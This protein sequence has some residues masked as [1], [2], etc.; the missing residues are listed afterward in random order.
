MRRAFA[1]FILLAV[2][3]HLWS[4]KPWTFWYWMY[5]AV[6]KE[7]IK[8]DLE[9][10]KAAGL[11]GCYLMPIRGVEDKP[12]FNG[13]AQQLSNTFW[14]MI[15]Y[16]FVTA[17]QLDLEM[18]IHVSDGFALAGG[19]WFTP[20][21]SMQKIVFSDT[22]VDGGKSD[23]MLSRPLTSS[24]YY[25]DIACY[26]IPVANDAKI[27]Y[28]EP[29]VS[30]SSN[31]RRDEKGVFR[32]DEDA[33][34]TYD[35]GVSTMV[36]A[37]EITPS[38]NNIQSQRLKV[39]VSDDGNSFRSIYQMEPPRQG[40]QHDG[41][42]FT[43]AIPPT[44]ARYFRLEW[45]PVGTQPGSE[46]LD[47]AKWRPNL[48]IS[49]IR[50]SNL[51]RVH[52][53]EGKAGYVWRV[54][55]ESTTEQLPESDCHRLKDIHRLLL[56]D[57]RVTNKLPKGKWLLLRIGHTTTGH[58]NATAGGGKGLEC[59]KFSSMAVTKQI[60]HWFNEFKKRKHSGVVKYLHVDSWECGSQ[61][62]NDCFSG[63]FKH[64]RQYNI[65]PYLPLLCGY[66]I[67]SA[68]ESE[69]VLRD[70]RKTI[71]ELIDESFFATV[72]QYAH[73][74]DC[75]LSTESVAPT[76]ISDGLTHYK[77]ADY[78]MGEFWLNSPTHD[79]PNDILDAIS[80]AHIYGK[81][82]VQAEGFTEVRGVWNESPATIKP[83][84]DRE[85]AL[86]MNKLF[87]HVFTH[88]PWT[89][90]QPGMTLDGIGL[91]FQRD[92]TWFPESKGLT[93]YITR[94]QQILQ[95]RMPVVDVAVFTG[96]EIPSRSLRPDQLVDILPG[97]IGKERVEKVIKRRASNDLT[98]EES[99]VGVRHTAGIIDL[100]DWCNA[101]RG[102]H[103]DCVN[104]EALLQLS[105]V[106]D[107]RLCLP[108]G[109][110]YRVLVIPGKTAMN[111]SLTKLS[112]EIR[113]RV[114]YLKQEGV[115][116]IE[117]PYLEDDFSQYGLPRD[118]ELPE[119]VDFIHIPDEL[120]GAR[121]FI[122]NQQ[123]CTRTI[124]ASFRMADP[125]TVV[126]YDPLA[127]KY[128]NPISVDKSDGRTIVEMKLAA[129]G[130]VFVI[131]ANK[132]SYSNL[133]AV[134]Y[135]D[136]ISITGPWEVKFERNGQKINAEA[137][138]DWS[139][140]TN[141]LIKYY[142]GYAAYTTKFSLRNFDGQTAVLRLD[143]LHDVAHVYV[144]GHDCGVV[145][146]APYE[147]DITNGL[148]PGKNSLMVKVVNTW[149]NA[150]KGNDEG[151]PPFGQ[152][153][154]NAKYREKT[155]ELNPAGLLGPVKILYE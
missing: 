88:N 56:K 43:F 114:D 107:G 142:S 74:H 79:K 93:D 129:Y 117:K 141:P 3:L 151:A 84:L 55:P 5:G 92:Q 24:D 146:T 1:C 7:G 113:K 115:I 9:A 11:G 6:S 50:F 25:E 112:D 121:Y 41:Y 13:T 17:E 103:Y 37:I 26:A 60:D 106:K 95:D 149:A 76:M 77:Y 16:A 80:G 152:I 87:F 104:S 100:A 128:Y 124:K 144:N 134:D 102:Y 131:C 71:A 126:I 32:S 108:G 69:R 81:K 140:Q 136:S 22:I 135:S 85:F 133:H 44:K 86:G 143:N 130:S 132:V 137:L 61:N 123:N 78:P 89:D 28:E 29:S 38:G 111:P 154:T 57:N 155:A 4:Q 45:S 10:M 23:F 148:K 33:W 153:W 99:P 30:W 59:D 67:E 8:A 116:V 42:A 27:W 18:G 83:L 52:Q 150:L 127:K 91:F 122:T 98:L 48:K 14:E 35:F 125:D 47:A 21:E 82:I 51:S 12:E 2:S 138:F 34:I 109:A 20:E 31:M 46:D 75:F 15:D 96:E 97:I 139:A 94:C 36:K 101:L 118:A 145:W 54:A 120:S 72:E 70:V 58:T 65:I 40:W 66:P 105:S 119:D 39:T 90:R 49:R 62:W 147:I 64:R 73:A 19:P 68:Q 63:E 53:F 110:S